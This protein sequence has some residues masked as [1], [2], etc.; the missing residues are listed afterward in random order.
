MAPRINL[1]DQD[2]IDASPLPSGHVGGHEEVED[3]PGEG[4]AIETHKARCIVGGG[5]SLPI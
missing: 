2:M 3:H 4:S 5:R 1:K